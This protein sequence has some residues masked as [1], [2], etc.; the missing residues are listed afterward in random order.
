LPPTAPAPAVALAAAALASRRADP[1]VRGRV[2][3]RRPIL[4]K[5]VPATQ[6]TEQAPSADASS[7]QPTA[8]LM[9][10][11]V[12]KCCQP[13][14]AASTAASV[15]QAEDLT[16]TGVEE[17]IPKSSP[18]KQRLPFEINDAV[19][20]S[21]YPTS[22]ISALAFHGEKGSGL[23]GF[24]SMSVPSV[25]SLPAAA[26]ER[27][28]AGCKE[29]PWELVQSRRGLRRTALVCPPLKTRPPPPAWLYGRCHR[30][31]EAGH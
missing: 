19:N 29:A 1:A 24:S 14:L 30:C 23:A 27:S 21:G 2:M 13:R 26:E 31:H 20:A 6:L 11:P 16:Q 8:P 25:S 7:G 4:S 10:L 5:A 9:Q 17:F 18:S 22:P 15:L 12:G 3:V 28:G